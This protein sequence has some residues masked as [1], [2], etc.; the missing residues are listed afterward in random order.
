VHPVRGGVASLSWR[1]ARRGPG[2]NRARPSN[3]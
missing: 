2:T 1:S 3:A